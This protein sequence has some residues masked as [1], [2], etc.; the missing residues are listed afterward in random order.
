[1]TATV[2]WSK[3]PYMKEW[4]IQADSPKEARSLEKLNGRR[5][6]F[7]LSKMTHYFIEWTNPSGLLKNIYYP[8]KKFDGSN[9]STPKEN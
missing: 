9:R 8:C 7:F 3:S 2:P 5:Q 4:M 6:L 1:M